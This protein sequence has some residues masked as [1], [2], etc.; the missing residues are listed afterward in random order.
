MGSAPRR[1]WS[2]RRVLVF[3]AVV[4][5]VTGSIIVADV[6]GLMAFTTLRRTLPAF[7]ERTLPRALVESTTC[8]GDSAAAAATAAALPVD[9]RSTAWRLGVS[10]GS[11]AQARMMVAR[12]A[13]VN[14]GA[15]QLLQS[16]TDTVRVLAATLRV[17]TSTF[18]PEH[19]VDANSE[20]VSF[21]ERSDTGMRL[22]EMYSPAACHLYK[23]GLY[24]GYALMP[25]TSVPGSEIVYAAE[26]EHHARAAGLPEHVWMPLT[27][28][29]P[30]GATGETLADEGEAITA[31]VSTYLAGSSAR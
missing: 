13:R 5:G 9:G 26:I 25:R 22:T 23:L 17:P 10:E 6:L 11:L 30:G 15:R 14:D 28:P 12:S 2:V 24:W 3:V 1:R 31:L 4:W 19:T 8:R 16:M 7:R 27:T 20:F 29:T 21:V 18:L